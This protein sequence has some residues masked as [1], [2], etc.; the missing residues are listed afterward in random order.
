MMRVLKSKGNRLTV[1]LLGLLCVVLAGCSSFASEMTNKEL[2]L[3]EN[4]TTTQTEEKKPVA[5][6][7]EQFIKLVADFR[8]EWKFA[9]KKPCVVDFYADWCRPCR[10]M[11]PAFAK[12]AEKYD[13]K[14]NFYKV[15]VDY[16]KDIS[17]AYQIAGIPTLFFCTADG[18]L[19]RAT[20]LLTEEQ[21]GTYIEMILEKK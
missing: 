20:G 19:T 15:N 8:K 9:G 16:N 5:I 17:T 14:V 12:M 1:S 11:E 3:P 13:G 18:K 7:Q 6:N 4:V 21:L 10:M 2:F